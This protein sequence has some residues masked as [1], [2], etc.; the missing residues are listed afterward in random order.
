MA[1]LVYR[2]SQHTY[3]TPIFS[4]TCF[5]LAPGNL[6]LLEL[7]SLGIVSEIRTGRQR[8]RNSIPDKGKRIF[9]PKKVPNGS[10]PTEPLLQ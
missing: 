1:Y 10:G 2:G 8:N 9:L 6:S 3:Y 4:P 7:I 5:L